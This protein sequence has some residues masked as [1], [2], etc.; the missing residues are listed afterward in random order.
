MR[1]AF[2]KP[3]SPSARPPNNASLWSLF[4]C[5]IRLVFCFSLFALYNWVIPVPF[6]SNKAG[7]EVSWTVWLFE[8]NLRASVSQ[9]HFTLSP[10]FSN[11][12]R[13]KTRKGTDLSV[14]FHIKSLLSTATKKTPQRMS[15][16]KNAYSFPSAYH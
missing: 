6:P 14:P 5:Y 16:N 7:Q 4:L 3:L 9:N 11:N 2:P 13:L 12:S 15:V 1:E 10:H 8:G